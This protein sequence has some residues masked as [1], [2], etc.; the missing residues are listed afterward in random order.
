MGLQVQSH[1][2]G[3]HGCHNGCLPSAWHAGACNTTSV[4]EKVV[5]RMSRVPWC[6]ASPSPVEA[7]REFA[8]ALNLLKQVDGVG[9]DASTC[10]RAASARAAAASAASPRRCSAASVASR[11]LPHSYTLSLPAVL[12]WEPCVAG[13]RV[14]R[15]QRMAVQCVMGSA[16]LTVSRASP[17]QHPVDI[18]G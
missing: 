7:A 9:V 17:C 18:L 13:L 2:T 1:F 8:K 12:V 14:A 3:C 6:P 15:A 11:S 10:A 5:P 16:T 4:T